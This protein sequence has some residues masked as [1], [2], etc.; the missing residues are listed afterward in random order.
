MLQSDHQNPTKLLAK[1]QCRESTILHY[2]QN[3]HLISTQHRAQKEFCLK[4]QA[5]IE[6]VENIPV[7][8]GMEVVRATRRCGWDR[9]AQEINPLIRQSEITEIS[10]ENKAYTWNVFYM[11]KHH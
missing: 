3:M 1:L 4:A 8:F 10:P 7:T 6:R 9:V 5:R 11:S 2:F